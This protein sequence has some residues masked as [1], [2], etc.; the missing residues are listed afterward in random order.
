IT[1]RDGSETPRKKTKKHK[2]HKSKKKRKKRKGEKDSSSESGAESDGDSQT[3]LI[4]KEGPSNVEGRDEDKESTKNSVAHHGDEDAKV[5]KAKRHS[6]KKKKKKKRKEEKQEKNSPSRSRSA[7]TSESGSES[8]SESKLTQA[9]KMDSPSLGRKSPVAA[10][11]LQNDRYKE[12]ISQPDEI[13][14]DVTSKA[15]Y[16]EEKLEQ[17]A[18][19]EEDESFEDAHGQA[20]KRPGCEKDT[21]PE[22]NGGF[23]KAHEL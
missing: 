21:K 18:W 2:K 16:C 20:A 15:E 13:K 12:K 10:A 3:K 9:L 17:P 19:R 1:I 8:E 11:K 22:K 14:G 23:S 5:K 4:K 7:S 6:G